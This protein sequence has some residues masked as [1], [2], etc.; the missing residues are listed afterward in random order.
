MV[1]LTTLTC[2]V[3]YA[4]WDVPRAQKIDMTTLYGPYLVLCESPAEFWHLVRDMLI[5]WTA[6]F[7]VVDM[8]LRLGETIKKITAASTAGGKK[9]Q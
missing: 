7:M 6:A 9:D 3:E 5:C 2:I 4:F 1:F 8:Y